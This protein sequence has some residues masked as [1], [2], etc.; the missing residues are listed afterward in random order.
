[1]IEALLDALALKQVDRAGW[2]REGLPHPESV[3]AH[4]WGV[5]WL[6]L[7][8]APPALDRGRMLTYA[9]LHDL[10]EAWTGD[11]T[12]HD[13]MPTAQKHARERSAMQALTERLGRPDLLATWEAYERQDDEEARFVRQLDRIDMALQARRYARDHGL[14]AAPF[15]ESARGVLSDPDLLAVLQAL[16]EP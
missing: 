2:V 11:V 1:M 13:G 6:V 3:A 7:A 12:P 4:S 5:S 9:V 8:L 14:N 10:A 16:T 15:L